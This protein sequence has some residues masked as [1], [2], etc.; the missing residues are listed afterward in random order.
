MPLKPTVNTSATCVLDRGNKSVVSSLEKMRVL[1]IDACRD[2]RLVCVRCVP[3]CPTR[4][5]WVEVWWWG[6]MELMK[7]RQNCALGTRAAFLSEDSY[8]AAPLSSSS[9]VTLH[10]CVLAASPRPRGLATGILH[11]TRQ[12]LAIP[13]RLMSKCPSV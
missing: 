2:R 3:E 13:S 1:L 12:A 4:S 6:Q 11:F 7:K 5:R 8:Q 9:E 10:L